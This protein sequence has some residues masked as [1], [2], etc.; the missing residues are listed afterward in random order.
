[1]AKANIHAPWGKAQKVANDISGLISVSLLSLIGITALK[2]F[3]S[4][5]VKS[6]ESATL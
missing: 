1:M 3:T 4:R 6:E 5:G 2:V